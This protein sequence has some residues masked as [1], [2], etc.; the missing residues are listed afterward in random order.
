MYVCT[1]MYTYA[2]VVIQPKHKTDELKCGMCFVDARIHFVTFKLQYPTFLPF[3]LLHKEAL[4]FGRLRFA[5]MKVFHLVVLLPLN[6]PNAFRIHLCK[7]KRAVWLTVIKLNRIFPS[8]SF[9]H[10][11]CMT[12]TAEA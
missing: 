2:M 1:M 8:H 6:G 10:I 4:T 5:E 11:F 3:F 9:A 7:R 12:I